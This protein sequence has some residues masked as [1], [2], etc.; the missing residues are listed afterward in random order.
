MDLLNLERSYFMKRWMSFLLAL[1]LLVSLAG[2]GEDA[3]TQPP[4]AEAE[5]L[6]LGQVNTVDNYAEFSLFKVYTTK[7]ITASLGGYLFYECDNDGETFVDMVLD[8]Q[9]LSAKDIQCDKLVVATAEG[10]DGKKYKDCL[11]VVE[12]GGGTS[13]DQFEDISPLT[14][15]RLHCGLYIPESETELTLRLKVKGKTY[16]FDY[17]LG[18]V[19]VDAVELQPGNTLEEADFAK[20]TF[21]GTEYTDDLRPSDTSGFYSHYPVDDPAN[22]YLVVKMDLTNLLTTEREMDKFVG[23]NI[24]YNGTYSYKGFMV[25]EDADGKGF[26]SYEDMSPLVTRH[27]YYLIEVPKAVVDSEYTITFSFDGK[28]YTYT[29]K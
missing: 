20:L 2:C 26:S 5:A 15:V 3:E 1:L 9:N 6:R 17:K 13:L 19:A 14:S 29:G 23:I 25:A 16:T 7:K 21:L 28:E 4:K 24:L 12:Q 18:D 22:T 27:L 11:Y 10:K 8:I